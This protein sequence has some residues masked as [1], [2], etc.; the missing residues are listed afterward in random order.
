MCCLQA[1][2]LACLL[3][4]IA[5]F[6]CLFACFACLLFGLLACLL[7]FLLACSLACLLSLSLFLALS[8]S[9]FCWVLGASVP[10]LVPSWRALWHVSQGWPVVAG[11]EAQGR[12]ASLFL[13][14][15]FSSCCVLCDAFGGFLFS[16]IALPA[17]NSTPRISSLRPRLALYTL[18]W[19]LG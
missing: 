16:L 5:C 6:A 13:L 10:W 4:L 9:P 8:L 2:L 15:F 19:C 3:C 11:L 18:C 7:A 12:P 14:V 17:P 1:C